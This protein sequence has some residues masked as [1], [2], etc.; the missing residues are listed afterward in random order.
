VRGV[1]DS[2]YG[3][4]S[5]GKTVFEILCTVFRIERARVRRAGQPIESTCSRGI[6]EI[7]REGHPDQ[8]PISTNRQFNH[9]VELTY[10]Y[11]PKLR[12]GLSHSSGKAR[13]APANSIFSVAARYGELC[14]R[15]LSPYGRR[16]IHMFLLSRPR[17]FHFP[18]SIVIFPQSL[19][20]LL[21]SIHRDF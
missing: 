21:H 18:L 19:D 17:R 2:A 13:T 10:E 16:L 5:G 12:F 20:P 7:L 11:N 15:E 1:N 4:T 3:H 14:R 8:Q 6:N 9:A